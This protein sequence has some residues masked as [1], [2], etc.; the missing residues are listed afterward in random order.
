M[1]TSRS[2]WFRRFAWAHGGKDMKLSSLFGVAL[3]A[4]SACWAACS[5]E[6]PVVFV[7]G[8]TPIGGAPG[9]G[10][11]QGVGSPPPIVYMGGGDAATAQGVDAGSLPTLSPE[12]ST[13]VGPTTSE[14]SG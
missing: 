12:A 13:T 8:Q 11:G 2:E 6:P 1:G 3:V 9:V 4:A 10:G 5:S 14:A 7:S